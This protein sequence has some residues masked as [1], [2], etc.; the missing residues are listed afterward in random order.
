M[1]FKAISSN[2]IFAFIFVTAPVKN[3]ASL[4]YVEEGIRF[5]MNSNCVAI[6]NI[7]LKNGTY[8]FQLKMES[9]T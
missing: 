3:P 9:Y 6:S 2:L 8:N 4:E 1:S 5:K 7:P